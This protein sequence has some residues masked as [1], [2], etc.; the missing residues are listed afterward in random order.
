MKENKYSILLNKIKSDQTLIKNTVF[1][2]KLLETIEDHNL[3]FINLC[4]DITNRK[5]LE[6]LV[7]S[8]YITNTNLDTIG[9][10]QLYRPY[11]CALIDK[12]IKEFYCRCI[13]GDVIVELSTLDNIDTINSKNLQYKRITE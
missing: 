4:V 2:N 3:W 7:E 5:Q 9:K 11:H 6:Y 13:I 8:R 12:D 1:F 10:I